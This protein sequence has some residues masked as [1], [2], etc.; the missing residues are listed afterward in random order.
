MKISECPVGTYVEW[1]GPVGLTAGDGKI[2]GVVTGITVNG[3]GEIIPL[4]A[5]IRR[6]IAGVDMAKLGWTPA[7]GDQSGTFW[8]RVSGVH[9]A[10]LMPLSDE[11][12]L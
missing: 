7:D 3:Y 10:Q 9:P 4:V 5:Q 1:T 12:V 11:T 8:K 2:A 6:K